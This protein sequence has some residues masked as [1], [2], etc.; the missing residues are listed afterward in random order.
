MKVLYRS[1]S[2]GSSAMAHP[3][4]PGFFYKK[5]KELLRRKAALAG[6]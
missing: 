2:F 6:A 3:T 5:T 1:S 4:T